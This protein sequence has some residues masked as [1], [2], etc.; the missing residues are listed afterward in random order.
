[1][2][3]IP[4]WPR[5]LHQL[6]ESSQTITFEWGRYDCALF[7][8]A[9]IREITGVDV[10]LS[11]R[12]TYQDEAGAEAIFLAGFA[13]LG[14]FAASIAAANSM[15]EVQVTFARRGDVVWVDNG[16]DENPSPYGALGIVGLDG[17]FAVCMSET[18]TKRVHMRRWKRAWQVG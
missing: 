14:A 12:G 9:A 18:G 5:R 8:C 10:G 13:D 4:S 6:I 3:R 7:V 17:R 1:M 16:I 2:Q 15:P 11:Y